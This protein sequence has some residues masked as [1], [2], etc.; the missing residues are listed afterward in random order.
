MQTHQAVEAAL[1]ERAGAEHTAYLVT[2]TTRGRLWYAKEA[3]QEFVGCERERVVEPEVSPV[4]ISYHNL[5][6]FHLPII[7]LRSIP[8]PFFFDSKYHF[9]EDEHRCRAYSTIPVLRRPN[10]WIWDLQTTRFTPSLG[11][12]YDLGAKG[13]GCRAGPSM[14]PQT[15]TCLPESGYHINTCEAHL[16]CKGLTG[17][18]AVGTCIHTI[19]ESRCYRRFRTA[20]GLASRTDGVFASRYLF[21]FCFGLHTTWGMR[22]RGCLL[23]AHGKLGSKF[24]PEK[25]AAV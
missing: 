20:R 19:H 23:Y 4:C 7:K 6:F 9:S 8:F 11:H 3:D 24:C 25:L 21:F 10:S 14:S 5:C 18:N 1:T 17:S 13:C 15:E 16:G 12:K 2:P 22:V